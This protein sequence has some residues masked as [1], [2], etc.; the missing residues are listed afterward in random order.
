MSDIHGNLTALDAVAADLNRAKPDF[1]L[2]GGDLA[3]SGSQPAEV[4]DLISQLGWPGVI[5]NTDEML[6]TSRPGPRL[7]TGLEM[8]YALLQEDS[9]QEQIAR[10]WTRL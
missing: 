7:V 8:M 9:P 10:S 4:I 5:G 1:V 2:H 3:A 6:W